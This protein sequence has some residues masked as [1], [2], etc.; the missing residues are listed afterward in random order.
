MGARNV[1]L[2][3]CDNASLMGNHHSHSQHTRWL[4]A[5]PDDRYRDYFEGLAEVRTALRARDVNL[6][7]L[8]PFLSLGPHERDFTQLCD[9]LELPQVVEAQADITGIHQMRAPTS[10]S[11]AKRNAKKSLRRR[12][13]A[14][15]LEWLRA[16]R[17]PRTDPRRRRR[18]RLRDRG[19]EPGRDPRGDLPAHRR[20]HTGP[21]RLPL[22]RLAAAA[23]A[24]LLLLAL[25]PLLPGPRRPLP[26][27]R[28]LDRV[29]HAPAR[30]PTDGP[31][32]RQ[33]DA[34][35]H[36][37]DRDVEPDGA[38]PHRERCADR[39]GHRGDRR[40]RPG[41]SSVRTSAGTARS[42]STR[43]SRSARRRTPCSRSCGR[44]RT[45]GSGSPAAS[46]AK[47]PSSTSSSRSRTSST[48]RT[49]GPRPP[50]TTPST[51]SSR[52]RA[53]RAARSRS[54]RR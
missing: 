37:G 29:L 49:S 17:S 42:G 3:G 4:G 21:G 22:R 39:E 52:R 6:V 10:A 14:P 23:G 5:E 54:S 27:Q 28:H 44:C 53:W 35:V 11:R 26:A 13:P 15:A 41:G 2:V 33:V 51:C 45:G 32:R 36:E 20:P 50:S 1:I 18:H 43:S 30:R 47:R 48:P 24:H 7:S 25:G 46:G 34:V 16:R 8:T 40:R 38:P 19:A 31:G 9:E 12:I